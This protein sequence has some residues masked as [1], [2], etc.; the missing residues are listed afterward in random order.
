[1]T[2]WNP[3]NI[4]KGS[5]PAPA[6]ISIPNTLSGYF[7]LRVDRIVGYAKDGYRTDAA[8]M[9]IEVFMRGAMI[10]SLAATKQQEHNRFTFS[11]PVEDRFTAAELVREAVFIRAR[12]SKGNSGQILL[13]GASQ[14]ELARETLGVPSVVVFDLDFGREGNARPYLG[15]GWSGAE[16]DD[17]WTVNDDSFVSFDTPTEPGTYVLRITAG[18]LIRKPEVS[19]QDLDVFIDAT[20]VAHIIQSEG[21]AQFNE[22]KFDHEAFAGGPRTTLRLHHPD[23]V[24]PFDLGV[25]TD[26]RRL[27]FC[28]KRLALVRLVP[29]SECAAP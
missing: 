26:T 4:F 7:E 17:T 25:N 22:C 23:A 2:R 14:I 8:T 12:D 5:R 28:F 6:P 21:F 1:M 27:A 11:F 19:G 29:A 3:F 16:P 15:A 18:A 9:Q 13:D 10:L 24:R 20:Q